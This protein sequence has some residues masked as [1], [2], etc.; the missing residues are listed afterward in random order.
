[1]RL[2]NLEDLTVFGAGS[3]WFW[4][5]MTM[6]ALTVTFL[7]ISR[8]LRAQRAAN[9]LEQLRSLS[10]EWL[11]VR[12]RH[13]CLRLALG[14]RYGVDARTESFAGSVDNFFRKLE[15]LHRQG[16]LDT[17]LLW[18]NFGEDVVRYWTVTA[19]LIDKTREAYQSPGEFAEWE[20]LMIVM[21]DL[22]AK[23]GFPPFE[24]DP[25]SIR[26]RIDWIIDGLLVALRFDAEV[27]K[28]IIPTPPQ[29]QAELAP[30]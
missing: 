23:R 21:R 27:R 13:I 18:T 20:R 26:G 30:A 25:D 9:A 2:L 12:M 4:T 22:M 29:A 7:A 1:M 3:E 15:L 8:Q 24:T 5:M 10:D 28:G 6:V 14:L 16:Y 17:E 19:D 11:S